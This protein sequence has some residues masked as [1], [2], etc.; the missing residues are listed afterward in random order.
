[1]SLD[2][3][4]VIPKWGLLT[5]V[6]STKAYVL[7][8]VRGVWW[9]PIDLLNDPTWTAPNAPFAA[10]ERTPTGGVSRIDAA[11]YHAEFDSVVVTRGRTF[12]MFNL[13][14]G[15]WTKQPDY[16]DWQ[17]PN[18]P[19][20]NADHADAAYEWDGHIFV[21]GGDVQY[22]WSWGWLGPIALPNSELWTRPNAPFPPGP[23]PGPIE[24]SASFKCAGPADLGE[25]SCETPADGGGRRNTCARHFEERSVECIS[26]KF[27]KATG[28]WEVDYYDKAFCVLPGGVGGQVGGT[29]AR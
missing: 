24:C 19:L 27:N 20:Q 13:S 12:F 1:V 16:L 2:A 7:D 14:T 22:D 11:Y 5:V 23:A 29:P 17:L 3:G 18:A 8:Y 10:A 26:E 4:Y 9:Q 28:K 25:I 15:Q 6:R 21:L